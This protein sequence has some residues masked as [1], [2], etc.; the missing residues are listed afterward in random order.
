MAAVTPRLAALK[1]IAALLAAAVAGGALADRG[2]SGH[3][4]G[5]PRAFG[6]APFAHHFRSA[7]FA[8]RFFHGR[9]VFISGAIVAPLFY[10]EPFYPAPYYPA[11]SYVPAPGYWYYCPDYRA[12]Y[13]YV[14]SCPSGWQAVA[15]Q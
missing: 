9:P 10:P 7:P 2:R 3:F 8:H 14:A 15:P 6:S 5:H 4:S 11:P 12:Y 13:P 1:L